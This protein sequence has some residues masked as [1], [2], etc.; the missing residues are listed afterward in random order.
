MR[1]ADSAL[2]DLGLAGNGVGDAEKAIEGEE[3]EKA[4]ALTLPF[5]MDP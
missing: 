5:T 4:G 3:R 2:L 1:E